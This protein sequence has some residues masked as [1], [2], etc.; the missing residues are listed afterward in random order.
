MT[1]NPLVCIVFAML[2]VGTVSCKPDMNVKKQKQQAEA[3]RNVGE[4]Y[5]AEGNFSAALRE[6]L[7]AEKLYPEDPFLHNDLGLAY[8]AKKKVTLA[9]K[10][11]KKALAINPEYAPALNNLGTAYLAQKQWDDAISCFTELTKNLIYATPHYPLSNLGRAYYAKKEYGLAENYYKEALELRPEFMQA[12]LGLSQTYVKTGRI[13]EAVET[14][15]KTSARYPGIQQIHFDLAHAYVLSRNY[16]KALKA[17]EKVI[18]L[19]SESPLAREA[20]KETKRIK[21]MR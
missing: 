14:L 10:H 13:S 5:M 4:A 2:I 8:M 16:E 20:K 19:A 17:Y 1:K 3:M 6:F 12:L 21:A 7:R 9:I 11:F 15:E 18:Q